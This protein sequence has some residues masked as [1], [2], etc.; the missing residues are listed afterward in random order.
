MT[1]SYLKTSVFAR[2]HKYDESPFS[3]IS[4]LEGVF[5]NTGYV[6]SAA[7]FGDKSFRFRKCPATCGRGFMSKNLCRFLL[8]SMNAITIF[9]HI[10]LLNTMTIYSLNLVLN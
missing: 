1:S 5:E 6:W 4:T 2:L 7:V 9:Y 10:Y 3:K 8:K